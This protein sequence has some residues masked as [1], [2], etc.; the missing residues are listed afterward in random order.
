M[1]YYLD[2]LLER[3]AAQWAPCVLGMVLALAALDYLLVYRPQAGGIAQ[4]EAGVEIARLEQARLRRQADR[5]PR[6]REEFAALRRAL[7]SRLPR[8]A[9]PVDPLQS[10][11]SRAA[12]AGLEMTRFQPGAAVAGE[13]LAEIPLEVEFTGTYHDLLR[14]LDTTAP[15]GSPDTRKL[16]VTALPSN[17]AATRLRI[18]MELVTL[19]LPVRE[20]DDESG[21]E[22]GMARDARVREFPEPQPFLSLAGT[23]SDLLPRDPFEPYRIPAPPGTEPPPE[24]DQDPGKPPQPIPGPRFHAAGILWENHAAT[25]LLKDAEGYHYLV[26]PGS[27]LGDGSN[28]V[29][30]ITP[31]EVVLETTRS[32]PRPTETRLLL[33]YCDSPEGTESR[34]EDQR[35]ERSGAPSY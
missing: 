13:F 7:H 28:H 16:T 5:L 34:R 11:T 26:R 35:P 9:E 20:P 10:V 4:V 21:E 30:T 1:Q 12:A 24:T 14:F 22:T 33:R 15:S 2:F 6:L 17:G 23:G 19:R 3:S 31:C 18:A 25:A 8:A 32:E 27:R 29:K